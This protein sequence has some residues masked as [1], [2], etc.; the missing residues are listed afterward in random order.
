M[1]FAAVFALV[2]WTYG[3]CD[4]LNVWLVLVCGLVW[5]EWL[6]QG[7]AARSDSLA[8]ASLSR[9]GEM[10]GGSPNLFAWRVAQAT[11][12][13]FERANVSLRRGK[14]RLSENAQMAPVFCVELSLRR[15]SSS[16]RESVSP[17]R[18]PSA[19]A[20]SWA[21]LH[22][23]LAISLL[24]NLRLAFNLFILWWYEGKDYAW[25]GWCMSCV[26]WV[27]T[28]C[29]YDN[30]MRWYM[31][32]KWWVWYEFDMRHERV[33]INVAWWCYETK[34]HIPSS[35]KMNWYGLAG[36]TKEVNYEKLYMMY[37]YVCRIC[38][39]D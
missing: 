33:G 36:N 26:L 3:W 34:F 27:L 5:Y 25:V 35:R 29:E 6:S 21:R 13:G 39:I 1:H 20:T 10:S 7:T 38:L 9:L 12:S 37:V 32:L 8:Q 19:W 17:E 30:C 31:K 23:G 4:V 15:R 22:V 11:R 14:S 18:G 2:L 28:W 16:E 24:L